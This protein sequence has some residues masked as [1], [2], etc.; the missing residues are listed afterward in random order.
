MK[1]LTNTFKSICSIILNFKAVKKFWE[2]FKA[3]RTLRHLEALE[4][5]QVIK[6]A[7][8]QEAYSILINMYRYNSTGVYHFM[9]FPYYK[10]N[11]IHMI[12]LIR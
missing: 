3:L 9:Y 6:Y 4:F 5:M 1:L 2:N 8:V 10:E 7:F 11:V 12:L